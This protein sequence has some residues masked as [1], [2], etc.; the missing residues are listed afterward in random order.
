MRF[1]LLVED[2]MEGGR[3]KVLKRGRY[4]DCMAAKRLMGWRFSFALLAFVA[5]VAPTFPEVT[6]EE[7]PGVTAAAGPKKHIRQKF[8]DLDADGPLTPEAAG[9]RY[10]R[11]FGRAARPSCN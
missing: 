8:A 11:A 10:G 9:T 7:C 3:V 1:V 2:R 6:E 5:E 4:A